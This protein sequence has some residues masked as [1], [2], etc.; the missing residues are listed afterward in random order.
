MKDKI[1]KFWLCS[2][3]NKSILFYL[4][5]L[6]SPHFTCIC[7]KRTKEQNLLVKDS[8]ICLKSK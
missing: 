6:Q 8:N 2:E 3:E 4:S 5:T 1:W 7:F